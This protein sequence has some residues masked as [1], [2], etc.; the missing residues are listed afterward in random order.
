MTSSG[1]A[2]CEELATEIRSP[3]PSMR[4]WYIAVPVP[5]GTRPSEIGRRVVA[6]RA[7]RVPLPLRLSTS[8]A[9]RRASYAATT[10]VRLTRSAP[11]SWRSEGMRWPGSRAPV[12]MALRMPSASLR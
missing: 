4:Y 8:P 12:S 5:P 11:A 3:G 7:I 10:V 2:P 1:T 6:F 9:S